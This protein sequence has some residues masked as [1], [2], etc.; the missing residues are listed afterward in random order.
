MQYSYSDNYT[1][2]DFRIF[3]WSGTDSNGNPWKSDAEI[4]AAIDSTNI[5][6]IVVNSYFDFNDF[7]QPIKTFLDDQF[8]YNL[9]SGFTKYVDLYI[10]Q[11]TVERKDSIFR[12]EPVGISS[13]FYSIETAFEK[14]RRIKNDN[15]AFALTFY[16]DSRTINYDRSVF[17]F[18]DWW[19]LIGGVNEILAIAGQLIVG[20]FSGKIFAFTLLSAIYQVDMTTSKQRKDA[21]NFEEKRDKMQDKF[22]SISIEAEE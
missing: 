18:L 7:V 1:Y 12:Y 10:R 21:E 4:D 6:V 2:F 22:K 14:I 3:R 11:N 16:K 13:S 20:L 5:V 19:G 8:Y 15:C 9:I 17:S